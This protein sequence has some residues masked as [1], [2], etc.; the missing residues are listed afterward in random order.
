M[1]GIAG[2]FIMIPV[3]IVGL[4]VIDKVFGQIDKTK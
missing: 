4:F 2:S 1:L 3:F